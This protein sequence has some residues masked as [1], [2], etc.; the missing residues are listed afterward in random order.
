[1]RTVIAS[2]VLAAPLALAPAAQAQNG[3]YAHATIERGDYAAA[4]HQLAAEARIFPNRPEVLLN[5]AAVY[6][7]TGRVSEARALYNR[8]LALRPV[9]MDVVD[10]KVAPSHVLATR[11]INQLQTT[12]V[13]AR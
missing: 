8:V 1:M 4:E 12:Q 3:P 11:G 2:I 10:G 9:A 13:A 5:L 6:A 7:R